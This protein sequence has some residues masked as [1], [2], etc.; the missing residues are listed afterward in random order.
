MKYL[1]I[2]L[3]VCSLAGKFK[4]MRVLMTMAL[5]LALNC[6][7][8]TNVLWGN[9]VS[10]GQSVR[11]NVAVELD[12]ITPVNRTVNGFPVSNDPL[13]T[14]SDINGYFAF[15]NVIW[16]QYQA[17]LHDSTGTHFPVYVGTNTLGSQALASCIRSAAV[18]PPNPG[19]NYYT[20]SQINALLSGVGGS[21]WSSSGNAVYPN[22]NSGNAGGWIGGPNSIY[23]Q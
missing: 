6:S 7:A 15:T 10:T 20:Q 23:P 19:T 13:L 2:K 12:L 1:K 3:I 9:L 11:T 8:Q 18:L 14:Y 16:G 21:L 17:L 4:L 22:G 5:L